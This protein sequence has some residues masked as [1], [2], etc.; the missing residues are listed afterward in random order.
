MPGTEDDRVVYDYR[1]EHPN[2][3]IEE[4]YVRRV[5]TNELYP[6]GVHYRMYYGYPSEEAII[7]F[8]NGHKAGEHHEHVRGELTVLDEFPGIAP[9]MDR[10]QEEINSHEHD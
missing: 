10:F 5:P 3:A 2:G 4:V 8:D 9:L 7:Q 6:E 1:V